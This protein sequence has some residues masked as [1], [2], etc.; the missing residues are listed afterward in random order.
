MRGWAQG[1]LAPGQPPGAEL[2]RGRCIPVHPSGNATTSP[3]Q[4]CR[5]R[6]GAGSP[7]LTQACGRR[8]QWLLCAARLWL[9]PTA[10]AALLL[11]MAPHRSKAWCSAPTHMSG[12]RACWPLMSWRRPRWAPAAAGWCSAG[13]GPPPQRLP[14][15]RSKQLQSCT[16][17]LAACHG[18]CCSCCAAWA[19]PVAA[20]RGC[21]RCAK[22]GQPVCCPRLAA[23][24]VL[25][26]RCA[27][28]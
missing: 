11:P 20:R 6:W 12:W 26:E 23:A 3:Q 8:R 5:Q 24:G 19:A 13:M 2:G 4:S 1:A 25:P 21:H 7:P 22:H 18:A 16:G 27:A 15:C 28:V 10:I 14:T 9:A 17:L